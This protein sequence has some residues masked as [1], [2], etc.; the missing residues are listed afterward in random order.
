[1]RAMLNS[2][3]LPHTRHRSFGL[4]LTTSHSAHKT[5]L[6]SATALRTR[7][8]SGTLPTVKSFIT[9]PHPTL[10]SILPTCYLVSRESVHRS[11][12]ISATPF[13][14]LSSC[15][16]FDRRAALCHR[17]APFHPRQPQRSA[18]CPGTA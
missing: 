8:L 18:L 2:E 10:S 9:E 14:F 7:P 11:R 1:M 16:T 12:F 3:R 17:A 6:C 13:I 4:S 15:F 5:A